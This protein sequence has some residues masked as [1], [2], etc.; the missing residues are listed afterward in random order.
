[1]SC[2]G[3]AFSA[4]FGLAILV[5]LMYQL[6]HPLAMLDPTAATLRNIK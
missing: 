1:V 2:S 4:C 5:D 6:L 3:R